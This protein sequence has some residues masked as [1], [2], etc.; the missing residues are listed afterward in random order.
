[1]SH[2]G[3]THIDEGSLRYMIEEFDVKSM[4]DIGCGPGGQVFLARRLK[5]QAVGI[6]NDFGVAP[7]VLHDYRDG[8]LP[9]GEQQAAF[10]LGWCVEFLEHIPPAALPNVWPTL[11]Q[12]RTLVVTA[13]PPGHG[14][15]GHVNERLWDYWHAR[16]EEQSYVVAQG[17]TVGL[18]NASTMD[19]NFI[20][21]RGYVLRRCEE[22]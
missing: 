6:D 16:F 14:G 22:W 10:D 2:L 18:R 19:R 11:R 9:Q 15:V 13:A 12:C 17:A 8:P 4:L 3:V 5:L 7:D 21:E 1:M 20:R